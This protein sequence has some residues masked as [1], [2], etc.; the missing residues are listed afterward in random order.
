M[1]WKTSQLKKINPRWSFESETRAHVLGI[2]FF[3]HKSIWNQQNT[4]GI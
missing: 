2:I 3:I 1:L 4:D